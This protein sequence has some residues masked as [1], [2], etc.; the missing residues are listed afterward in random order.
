MSKFMY[1]HCTFTMR[2]SVC[3]Y[4]YF[5]QGLVW[6][7]PPHLQALDLVVHKLFINIIHNKKKTSRYA[8]QVDIKKNILCR[9]N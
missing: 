6:E 4:L 9:A 1:T 7:V 5:L 2:H 8:L 3:F